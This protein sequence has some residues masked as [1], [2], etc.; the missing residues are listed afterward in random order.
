M[1]CSGKA[2]LRLYTLLALK[3]WFFAAGSS[4]LSLYEGTG[5]GISER[6]VILFY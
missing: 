1:L 3:D 6:L 4:Q 2:Q 5:P